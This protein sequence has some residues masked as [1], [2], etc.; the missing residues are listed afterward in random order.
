[1]LATAQLLLFTVQLKLMSKRI[2]FL[3]ADFAKNET[4]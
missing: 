4:I 3:A 2:I 1:M